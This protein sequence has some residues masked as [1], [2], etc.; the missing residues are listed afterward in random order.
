MKCVDEMNSYR[1]KLRSDNPI[2]PLPGTEW[3]ELIN[4]C[5]RKPGEITNGHKELRATVRI[6]ISTK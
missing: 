5:M 3:A 2:R 4:E 1:G 6:I